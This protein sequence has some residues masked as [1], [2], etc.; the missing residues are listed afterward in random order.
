MKAEAKIQLLVIEKRKF[1]TNESQ[2][3]NF[4]KLS[5]PIF[6]L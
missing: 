5:M 1:E 6:N 2:V 3:F 4:L